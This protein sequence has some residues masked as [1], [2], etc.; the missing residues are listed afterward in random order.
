MGL[1][2]AQQGYICLVLSLLTS[3]MAPKKASNPDAPAVEPRRS[4]RIASM[5]VPPA[6]EVTSKPK[7]S[8]ATKKRPAEEEVP[9]TEIVEASSSKKV[10]FSY[11]FQYYSSNQDINFRRNQ[12]IRKEMKNSLSL[13]KVVMICLPSTSAI[14]C[15]NLCLKM[16]KEKI[17]RLGIWLMKEESSFS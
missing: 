11:E 2:N 17:F 15:P 14:V 1:V 10:H 16:R 7:A 12:T 3:I 5:P 9:T 8:R 6:S 13:R 4:G